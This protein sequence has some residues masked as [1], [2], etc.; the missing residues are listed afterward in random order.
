MRD[1]AVFKRG[2]SAAVMPYVEFGWR[3]VI[4]G[5]KQKASAPAGSA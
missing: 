3:A 2:V 5:A 4:E 1:D